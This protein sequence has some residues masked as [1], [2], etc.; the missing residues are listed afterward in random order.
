[1]NNAIKYDAN[2]I[3]TRLIDLL[4]S[5]NEDIVIGSEVM[6]GIER[7]VADVLLLES[8]RTTAFEIKSKY[9]SFTK[10]ESQLAEYCKLF[11]YVYVVVDE[12][13]AKR[14]NSTTLQEGVGVLI[15]T[16]NGDM[17]F[18]R[19]AKLQKSLSKSEMAYTV[20]IEYIRRNHSELKGDADTIRLLLCRKA[21]KTVEALFYSF[22]KDKI[23][24]RFQMFLNQRGRH[25]H[26]DDLF[27]LS[28]P[29]ME[30]Q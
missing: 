13:F 26:S 27:L 19:K 12:S 14:I 23:E 15:V 11:N 29:N 20:N 18:M 1:M 24:P 4:I 5:K 7:K 16:T 17:H 3:K 30:I 21:I 6:Y 2:Y 9:D 28:F 10:L 22:L 8:N 25:T